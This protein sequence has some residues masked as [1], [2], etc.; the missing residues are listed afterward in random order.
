MS[1]RC[2]TA[3]IA[4]SAALC[5]DLLG[6]LSISWPGRYSDQTVRF[7]RGGTSGT[8]EGIDPS[9]HAHDIGAQHVALGETLRSPRAPR[10]GSA[11]DGACWPPQEARGTTPALAA[12]ARELDALSAL[13]AHHRASAARLLA[14]AA[15]APGS[16]SR[17][18]A[19]ALRPSSWR[20]RASD[21]RRRGVRPPSG[22]GARVRRSSSPRDLVSQG[23]G[24]GIHLPL[25]RAVAFDFG[26][27]RSDHC[28]PSCLRPDAEDPP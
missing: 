9:T 17:S 12:S 26:V 16:T 8:L 11:S 28:P 1:S 15:I 22:S 21:S 24:D 14:S 23:V 19:P 4:A 25:E 7:S 3:S 27:G 20:R 6:R 18:P 5:H 13:P 2:A 10:C